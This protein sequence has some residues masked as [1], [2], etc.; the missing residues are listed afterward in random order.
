MYFAIGALGMG[1]FGAFFLPAYRRRAVRLARHHLQLQ[2]PMSMA[3]ITARLDAV[4]AEAAAHQ[5]AIEQQSER[6]RTDLAE[7]Q[8]KLGHIGNQ[9]AAAE[10]DRANLQTNYAAALESLDKA[11][12]EIA[13]LNATQG[14][15]L[16]ALHNTDQLAAEQRLALRAASGEHERLEAEI[17]SDRMTIAALSTRVEGDSLTISDLRHKLT[18]S[19]GHLDG[20]LTVAANLRQARSELQE[21]LQRR[22]EAVHQL[23]GR[24]EGLLTR[25]QQISATLEQARDAAAGLEREVESWKVKFRELEASMERS[26]TQD[27]RRDSKRQADDQAADARLMQYEQDLQA[28]RSENATLQ[29]RIDTLTRD[30][31]ATER[32]RPSGGD[33]TL[34]PF[35]GVAASDIAALRQTIRILGDEVAAL[36]GKDAAIIDPAAEDQ[37]RDKLLQLQNRQ[38]RS[39][40][41]G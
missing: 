24:H 22:D 39:V 8:A 23:Q 38:P 3:D 1:L 10:A 37:V 29:G 40:A 6:A 7:Q 19:A 9:L 11:R 12:V 30:R 41:A 36:S 16:Q 31:R 2:M 34:M 26:K 25:Y 21:E 14:A 18:E 4:R 13:D 17:Q 20:A 27:S 28:L 32:P 5:R 33:V 15:A 35:S